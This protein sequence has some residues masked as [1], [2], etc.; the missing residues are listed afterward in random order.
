MQTWSAEDL[1][2]IDSSLILEE[3]FFF[4]RLRQMA[5]FHT[6]LSAC[7]HLRRGRRQIKMH[8]R[9]VYDR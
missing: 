1:C 5:D 2:E 3:I 7:G 4:L 6:S 9:F 8:W